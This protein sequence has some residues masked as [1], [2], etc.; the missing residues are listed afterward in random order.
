MRY[1]IAFWALFWSFSMLLAFSAGM[2]VGG[3]LSPRKMHIE[4]YHASEVIPTI[5]AQSDDISFDA[6]VQKQGRKR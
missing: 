6:P 5:A 3:I 1:K 2:A 4:H